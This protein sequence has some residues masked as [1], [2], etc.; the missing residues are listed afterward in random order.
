M[1]AYFFYLVFGGVERKVAWHR[2]LYFL[3]RRRADRAC[4]SFVCLFGIG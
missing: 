1:H 4:V 2:A 3:N